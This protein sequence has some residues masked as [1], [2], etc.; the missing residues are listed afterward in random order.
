M[1]DWVTALHGEPPEAAWDL[2]LGRYRR[3]I[4]AAIRHYGQDYD[5]AMDVFARVCQALRED[6]FRRLR[7]YAE[8]PTHP[9][10]VAGQP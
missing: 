3:L 10:K 6:D 5:D 1:E 2:F 9:V 4:F 8:Q 7:A